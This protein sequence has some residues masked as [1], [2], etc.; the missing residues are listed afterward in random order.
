MW[1]EMYE[2]VITNMTN[3]DEILKEIKLL[4]EEV[5]EIKEELKPIKEIYRDAT[6]FSH[7]IKWVVGVL[8]SAGAVFA[9]FK[10]IK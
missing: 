5:D 9:V 7:I 2:Q 8:L 1:L 10:G 6:G 4:R 3:S